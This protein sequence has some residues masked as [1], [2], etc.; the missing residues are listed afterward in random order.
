MSLQLITG[1]SGSGKSYRLY[2]DVIKE[3]IANPGKNYIVIV[4]EQFTMGTQEKIVKMH[5]A[6]G[7]F[8]VDIVSF[9]RLAYK[10]FEEMGVVER[11]I[12][13]DTG[14]SLIVRKILEDNKDK[15]SVFK[16]NIDKPG[17]VEEVKSAISEMLQYGVS[18]EE[19]KT[20]ANDVKSNALFS[21][22]LADMITVFEGFKSYI[23]DKFIASEE[24]LE[25]LCRIAAKSE[26]IRGSVITLDGFTGFTP[27][28][29]RLI[30]ILMECCEKISV[31]MTIDSREKINVL[32][33][34]DNLFYLSKNTIQKL[35]R[36]ADE[37]ECPILPEIVMEDSAPVRL[38][39]SEGLTFLE[40]NIFRYNT[41]VMSKDDGSVIIC[42]GL[43][44]KNEIAFVTGEIKRLVAKEGYRY[45]DFAIVSAD[46]ET[47]GELAVNILAQNMIPSFLDYKRNVMGNGAVNFLRNALRV[48]EEDFS[49]ESVFSF[50]KCGF[51]DISRDEIDLL[52]NYCL[53]LGVRGYAKYN[54]LWIRMTDFLQKS[55]ISIEMINSVRE[56]LVGVFAD[57]RENVKN[58]K[59]VT[60]YCRAL[61]DFMVSTGLEERLYKKAKAFASDGDLSSKGEYEQVYGKIIGLLDKFVNLLGTEKISFREFNDILDAGFGEIKVGLIPQASDAVMIGDIERT[62]LENVKILFFVG[63]NDGI[64]PQKA[65]GGGIISEND[66]E[67]L[68]ENNIELSMTGRE[69][70]FIQKFYLYLNLTKPSKKLYLSY[71]KMSSDG[72]ARKMSY[73][74]ISIR[75]M[76]P[77]IRI[78]TEE[79][80]EAVL[81][82]VRIPESSYKWEFVEENLEP[83]VAKKLYGEN[84]LTSI[85]AIERFSACEFAHFVTYGLRLLE[86]EKYDVNASDIGTLYHNSLERFSE[87][88]IKQGKTFTDIEDEER[89]SLIT[90]SVMEI[91]TDY[92][93]TVLYS[94]KRNEYMLSRV[95]S[96]ADRTVWA[97]GKQLSKGN[98]VP[99]EF[100]KSFVYN[101]MVHGRI[102]RID[103]FKDSD[104]VYVKVVDYKTGESDFDLLDT[105][106]GLKV[107][108]ITYMN[109]ALAIEQ[110]KYPD[111]EIVPAGMFYYNIKNPFVD[112]TE[113]IDDAILEKLRVKGVVNSSPKVLDALDKEVTGS[114][115]LVV[116]VSFNKD[117][118]AKDSANVLTMEKIAQLSKYVDIYMEESV[119]KI[120]DGAISVNP[121]MK[122]KKTG[123]DYCDFKAICGFDD[124]IRG[125]DY[126]NLG[127]I[128]DEEVFNRVL[129]KIEGDENGTELD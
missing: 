39:D 107:Q 129:T 13:D 41:G 118:E 35:K 14:K 86:R 93:N 25:I 5:P 58:S 33:G 28:Q 115:S 89:K 55:E 30:K 49:Y 117:G 72:N 54:S 78:L 7:V 113:E 128:S 112:E 52:E 70:A 40:K 29:Y 20:V 94:T 37:A 27:I 9:P 48:I 91:A 38:K 99:E 19:L 116:P 36:I 119:E 6:K 85:S 11:E 120:L 56:K 74:L 23:S 90:E 50:L 60:D 1:A 73:L 87:K 75:K 26:I 64:I 63:V 100:E 125:C 71:S 44:P 123:C 10:V 104:A 45:R 21:N 101:K 95:I 59:T 3:S 110:K 127:N 109:A 102:D 79:T 124:K 67:L 111:K 43:M 32:D 53:A 12:L 97:I 106:Y 103:T 46:I 126:R 65:T 83:E 17:F 96:M 62:R 2:E 16:K 114:K 51:T 4:P 8:N 18:I 108:L 122:D 77:N 81:K 57:F 76:F 15:L 105:Y 66:K 22:K 82:L 69:K 121:Y 31:T 92:G 80:Q 84:F 47:Y 98:F 34:I 61:Y 42:E 68:R 24:I 88:L